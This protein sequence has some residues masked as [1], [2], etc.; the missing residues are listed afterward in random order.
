MVKEKPRECG[1]PYCK[2]PDGHDGAC[3]HELKAAAKKRG[4]RVDYKEELD[5]SDDDKSLDESAVDTE[6]ESDDEK[7]E[8]KEEEKE[9]LAVFDEV[10]NDSSKP[11]KKIHYK[12]AIN[13]LAK[14]HSFFAKFK[15]KDGGKYYHNKLFQGWM[16]K[17]FPT[18]SYSF[19]S[20]WYDLN[21]NAVFDP[22]RQIFVDPETPVKDYTLFQMFKDCL[23]NMSKGAAKDIRD[24]LAKE[25]QDQK[26]LK[27]KK[28]KL[29]E[30]QEQVSVLQKEVDDMEMNSKRARA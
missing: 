29:A 3:D 20:I 18:V 30:V 10:F 9:A 8:E 27:E 16:K 24:I 11:M 17:H 25:K 22:Q 2:Q 15:P 13:T 6:L 28:R 5:A 7:E 21:T 23:P 14:H 1:S 4:S 12:I 19:G 26:V